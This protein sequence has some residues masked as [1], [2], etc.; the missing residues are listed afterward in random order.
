MK[1][2]TV[3]EVSEAHGIKSL[4]YGGS[5]VG[6]SVLTATLPTP[7]LISAE[8]GVLSLRKQN[9]ERIFGSDDPSITYD[10]PLAPI[11]TVEDLAE[12]YEWLASSKEA[13]HFESVALDSLSE[14]GE[15]VL[16]NAK[17]Q[18]KDPRQAYGELIEKVEGLVRAFRDLPDKHVVFICKMEPMKDEMTG[19]VRW[20]PS[21]P[22]AK[23]SNKLPYFC[24]QVMRLGI[25]KT[26]EGIQYR[27]LQNQPDLQFDAKDRSGAL[28]PMEPPHLGQAFAKILAA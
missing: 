28:E 8:A 26:I 2:T 5:G 27:F 1:I 16:A 23:L 14:I 18:V 24:D 12:V 20:V 15:V 19:V 10:M 22:G 3:S 7:L 13:K 21:M 9:L 11:A 17:R 25:N 6:K 4:I